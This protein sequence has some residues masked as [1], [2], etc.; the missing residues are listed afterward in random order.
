MAQC[1]ICIWIFGTQL[2]WA[3]LEMSGPFW[4]P[5]EWFGSSGHY[6]PLLFPALPLYLLAGIKAHN[7]AK[8][9]VREPQTMHVCIDLI[10]LGDGRAYQ[11]SIPQHQQLVSI[12]YIGHTA[13]NPIV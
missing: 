5:G 3:C 6:V 4:G 1:H 7:I 8:T 13:P 12:L 2:C 10:G 9:L 11:P